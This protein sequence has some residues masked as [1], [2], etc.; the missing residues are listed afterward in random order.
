MSK[1]FDIGGLLGQAQALQE[2]LKSAQEG[3]AAR[4]VEG[5]AGGGMVRAVVNGRIEVV[6]VT[7]EPQLLEDP[8]VEML[9][10]LVTAA[11][12]DAIRRAQAM[13]ADE[14]GKLTGGLGLKLP[15]F[16]S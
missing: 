9:Q 16:G 8:D 1:G 6:G 15:G 4:S 12:N 5:S 2:K 3:L 7:I 11:V 14:M 10:D 13:V